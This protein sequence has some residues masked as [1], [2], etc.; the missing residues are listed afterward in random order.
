MLERIEHLVAAFEEAR[1]LCEALSVDVQQ[2][3]AHRLVRFGFQRA[4]AET[5]QRV[6]AVRH[7]RAHG[8]ER[9]GRELFLG[10][11]LVQ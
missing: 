2:P 6:A 11:Q 8:L 7:L 10:A 1:V 9:Q 3:H 4:E 5:H